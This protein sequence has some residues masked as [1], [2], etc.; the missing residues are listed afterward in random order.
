[1]QDKGEKGIPANV[2]NL[3]KK[4]LILHRHKAKIEKLN[5]KPDGHINEIRAGKARPQLFLNLCQ[6]LALQQ[7]R[8]REEEGQI[9]GIKDDDVRN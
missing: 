1:M 3:T 7:T 2:A 4:G 6:T 8:D 5:G 9:H